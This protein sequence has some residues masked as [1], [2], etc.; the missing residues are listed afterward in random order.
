VVKPYR[1]RI[2]LARGEQARARWDRGLGDAAMLV[3]APVVAAGVEA[4]V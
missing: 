3:V 4:A 2:R 1:L